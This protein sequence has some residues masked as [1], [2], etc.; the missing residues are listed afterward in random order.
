M[1]GDLSL[2][3][4]LLAVI[5]GMLALD[6]LVFHRDAHE[7]SMR[8]AAVFSAVWI[9]LGIGFGGLV[10]AVRGPEAGGEYLAGYLI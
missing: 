9:A 3:L 5:V 10:F 4:I 6:L 7:V 8:E 2:W 1:T